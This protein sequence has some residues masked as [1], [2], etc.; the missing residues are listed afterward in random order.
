MSNDNNSQLKKDDHCVAGSSLT[1]VT[2]SV[3]GC[4]KAF[5]FRSS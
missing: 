5:G 3:A 2:D 1:K 4:F